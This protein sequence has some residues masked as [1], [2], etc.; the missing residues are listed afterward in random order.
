MTVTQPEIDKLK[1]EFNEMTNS[2]AEESPIDFY[3]YLHLLEINR[4]EKLMS[5]MEMNNAISHRPS[6]S[7]MK[8]YLDNESELKPPRNN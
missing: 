2:T 8:N 4:I 3:A 6:W 7:E 1:E 5:Y